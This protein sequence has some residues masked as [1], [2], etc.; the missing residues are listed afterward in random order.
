[1]AHPFIEEMENGQ[2]T[3]LFSNGSIYIGELKEGEMHGYGTLIQ[4]P[5]CDSHPKNEPKIMQG[6][7]KN[8]QAINQY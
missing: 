4:R 1:M 2:G 3:K 5:S 8:N 7:W 6:Y